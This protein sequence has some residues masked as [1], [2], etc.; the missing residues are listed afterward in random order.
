[1]IFSE[2]NNLFIKTFLGLAFDIISFKEKL[3]KE[4]SFRKRSPELVE[5]KDPPIIINIK[6]I[7][8]R[9]CGVSFKET[10]IFDT[11]L[12]IDK[13]IIEKFISLSTNKKKTKTKV[14][15]YAIR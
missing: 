4:T 10:P 1:M 7:N 11:L 8:D 14:I 5:K 6:K 9:Y 13:K 3:N 15:R 12:N 2:N